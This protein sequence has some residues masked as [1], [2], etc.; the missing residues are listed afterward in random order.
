M[1]QS[2]S[3]NTAELEAVLDYRFRNAVHLEEALT[4]K[5]YQHENTDI[6]HSYNERLEFLGDSVLGLV[7]AE[8][9]FCIEQSFTEADMSKLKAYLVNRTVLHEIGSELQIGKYLRLGRGEES[10]LGRQKQSIL[11][12]A[13][14]ALIGALFLDSDYP[15]AKRV[16]LRLYGSRI[17]EAVS[18]RAW[19]DYKSALQER[20]QSEFGVLP[21]YYV[22]RQEGEEHRKIFTVEVFIKGEPSGCGVGRSKKDAQMA[23]AREALE[24]TWHE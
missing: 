15:S 12:N 23:A 20:C 21:E 11:A 16:I 13:V 10:T 7:V 3:R 18:K 17:S 9:L 19:Y 1:P 2:F 5:S 4:H 14:E 8:T 6:S 22:V 24:Q